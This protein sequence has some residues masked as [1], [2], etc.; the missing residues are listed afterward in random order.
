MTK[1]YYIDNIHLSEKKKQIEYILSNADDFE[2][3]IIIP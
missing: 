3:F 2:V 1:K